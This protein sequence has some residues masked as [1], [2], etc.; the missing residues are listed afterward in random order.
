MTLQ[1]VFFVALRSLK[2]SR[3]YHSGQN[4]SFIPFSLK[5]WLKWKSWRL[6]G[7]VCHHYFWVCPLTLFIT[8]WPPTWTFKRNWSPE[9]FL[10]AS[11]LSFIFG[12]FC[13][14]LTPSQR[15]SSHGNIKY[16]MINL[17]SCKNINANVEKIISLWIVT[18]WYK[19]E[20]FLH[21]CQCLFI[22]R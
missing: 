18:Q 1:K 8:H 7:S 10:I 14:L 2:S 3:G 13:Q 11:S 4:K 5:S 20:V 19:S 17:L 22:I 6:C 16:Q 15:H 21:V 9:C 12:I